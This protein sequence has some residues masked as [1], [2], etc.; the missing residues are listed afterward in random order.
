[1]LKNPQIDP[2][3]IIRQSPDFHQENGVFISETFEPKN[4]FEEIYL[5]LRKKESR[6]YDDEVLSSLPEYPAGG[7]HR[8]EWK[9]RKNS[10]AMLMKYLSQKTRPLNILELGCG[11][12][13]LASKISG[14]A[15]SIVI[16]LD[17][18]GTELEQA[19]RVFKNKQ[20]LLFLRADIYGKEIEKLKF[21]CIILAGI[22]QYF[23][24]LM[25]LI[26]RLLQLT[27]ENG[28]VH[29]IDSPIYNEDQLERAIKR[30]AAYF[31]EIGMEEAAPLFHHHSFPELAGFNSSALYSP[32]SIS[33][34]IKRRI[35]LGSSSPFSWLRIRR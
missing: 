33:S 8:K 1:M 29:I 13:W 5:K 30:S 24:D 34:R 4:D 3:S 9:I 28:E 26:K 27:V 14:I 6:I 7:P 2:L 17:I 11:N 31:K 32:K 35:L 22:I 25:N 10:A 16:G 21:D 15:G 23:A 12:G 19:A 18:N 20:N